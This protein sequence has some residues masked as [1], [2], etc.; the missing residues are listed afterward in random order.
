MAQDSAPD[1]NKVTVQLNI[2]IT[3][4]LKQD[5]QK[6]AEEK[7]QSMAALVR[8]CLETTLM[9]ELDELEDR[10]DLTAVL[11]AREETR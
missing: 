2:P 3:W 9:H 7:H 5:L 6:I 11:S 8:D 10:R 4:Q 1:P